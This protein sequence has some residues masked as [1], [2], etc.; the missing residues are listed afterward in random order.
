MGTTN[1]DDEIDL[2]E[3]LCVLKRK[4]WIILLTGFLGAIT[5]GSY[6]AMVMEPVF[7]S[8]SMLYVLNKTTSL[9]TLADIQLGTQ[10]T[11]DYKILITSRPVT[12]QVID[13]LGLNMT[14]EQLVK[15]IKV[16]NPVDTR[17]LTIS[18]EDN[19]PYVAKSIADEVAKAASARM[20]KIMDSVP[21]DIVEEGYLPINKT[22]PS[23]IKNS[24]SGGFAV[25]F[26]SALIILILCILNDTVKTPEDVERYL[27]L[28]TLAVIPLYK[29]NSLKKKKKKKMKKGNKGGDCHEEDTIP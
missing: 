23:I 4:L 25:I 16:K 21:P 29:E 27:G 11:K 28:N 8:S 18:V 9:T 14:H 26:L 24:L 5:A 6:T 7:T 1:Q 15:K 17:I 22:R 20:A 2:I 19:D 13:D 10:L 3:L 12:S